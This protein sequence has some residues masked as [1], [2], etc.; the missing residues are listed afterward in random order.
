VF[1][2]GA[3]KASRQLPGPN[4]TQWGQVTPGTR[5]Q[6]TGGQTA[7]HDLEPGPSPDRRPDPGQ[8]L[9]PGPER[10]PRGDWGRALRKPGSSGAGGGGFWG[11]GWWSQG[12]Q[13]GPPA[14]CPQTPLA[15]EDR[16]PHLADRNGS[17]DPL[18]GEGTQPGNDPKWWRGTGAG[19][20]GL[21]IGLRTD[22]PTPE[23]TP[24][25]G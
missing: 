6:P 2:L 11:S 15:P 7:G 9:A 23:V 12:D 18:P 4:P 8:G 16:D 17:G 25:G 24:R 20:E 13:A 5:A 14:L 10:P 3:I 1:T 19:R 21:K 22:V